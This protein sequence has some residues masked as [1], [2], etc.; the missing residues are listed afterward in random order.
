MSLIGL[1]EEIFAMLGKQLQFLWNKVQFL[2][3]TF[4]KETRVTFKVH[5]CL[6]QSFTIF[7]NFMKKK[8]IRAWNP[9]I[10]ETVFFILWKQGSFADVNWG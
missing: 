8:M 5:S 7:T 2:Q 4:I 1:F 6:K 9:F 10:F 3:Q